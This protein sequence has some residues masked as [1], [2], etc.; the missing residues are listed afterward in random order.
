MEIT[1]LDK[2]F[3]KAFTNKPP[4]HMDFQSADDAAILRSL[5]ANCIPFYFD[6]FLRQR[7][8]FPVYDFKT[9]IEMLEGSEF[10]QF[11]YEDVLDDVHRLLKEWERH[12]QRLIEEHV[13]QTWHL[14]RLKDDE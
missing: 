5:E 2:L 12:R 9:E 10:K 7:N 14:Y 1:D 11:H 6:Y 8:Y 13:I 3:Y 4:Q